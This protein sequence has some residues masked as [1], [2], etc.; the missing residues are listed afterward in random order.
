MWQQCTGQS[1]CEVFSV[2]ASNSRNTSDSWALCSELSFWQLCI[3]KSFTCGELSQD[4]PTDRR[5]SCTLVWTVP[6]L[7]PSPLLPCAAFNKILRKGPT[8]DHL[9]PV[10]LPVDTDMGRNRT[11]WTRVLIPEPLHLFLGCG[12]QRNSTKI[13]QE[14]QKGLRFVFYI[15]K[16][17]FLKF[18][19]ILIMCVYLCVGVRMLVQKPEEAWRGC[20]IPEGWSYRQGSATHHGC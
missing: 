19:F 11:V 4:T 16:S 1:V 12:S 6:S 10:S 5:R 8:L 9:A 13:K 20:W 14:V 3:Q 7:L 18:Y 17:V 15:V 2:T